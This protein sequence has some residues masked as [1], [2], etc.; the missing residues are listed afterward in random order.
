M[1]ALL[2]DL[3]PTTT[4]PDPTTTNPVQ[5]T[6]DSDPATTN[7]DQ[8]NGSESND[9][10]SRS[11]AQTIALKWSMVH[12]QGRD[13]EI[14]LRNPSIMGVNKTIIQYSGTRV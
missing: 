8:N 5:T 7:L 14:F 2:T 12:N 6:M 9:N 1:C 13:A 10:L 4:E 11:N 3:D